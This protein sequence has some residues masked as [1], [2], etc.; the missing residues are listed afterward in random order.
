MTMATQITPSPVISKNENN[1]GCGLFSKGGKRQKRT[2]TQENRKEKINHNYKISEV[3]R[4][5]SP[6]ILPDELDMSMNRSS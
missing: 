3:W 6:L 1:V 4:I 2:N 5:E